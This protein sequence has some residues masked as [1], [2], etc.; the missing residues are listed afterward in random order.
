MREEEQAIMVIMGESD[1]RNIVTEDLQSQHYRIIY[2]TNSN[3]ARLKFPNEKF[4]YLIV[5]L[6]TE[7]V[8]AREFIA[9]I[10]RKELSKNAKNLLPILITS[11]DAKIYH[12]QFNEFD[13]TKFLPKPFS[14]TEFKKTMLTFTGKADVIQDNSKII[15]EGEYLINEGGASNEMFWVISGKFVI[16][17]Q[18]QDNKNVIIGEVNPGELVGEMSF[19]D[20]LPRSASVMAKMDSEV[21]VIPHKKFV[22]VFDGQPLWFRSLM[23]TLSKRLRS[24]NQMIARKHAE[25]NVDELEKLKDKE[26]IGGV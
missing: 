9:N 25:V 12:E 4:S 8:H 21:L 17:K 20:S 10:R 14:A 11:Y 16:T 18:N 2:A 6:D 24:A 22:S 19:L 7:G 5:D 3:E 23:R 13:N 26:K 15:K 1:L